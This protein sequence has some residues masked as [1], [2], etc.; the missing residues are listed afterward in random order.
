M[1]LIPLNGFTIF[2]IIVVIIAALIKSFSDH[3]EREHRKNNNRNRHPKYKYDSQ[4]RAFNEKRDIEKDIST[5]NKKA[6]GDAYEA[7]VGKL[8][9]EKGYLVKYQ[10]FEKG[11]KDG[12]IDLIAIKNDE[13]IFIQCKHWKKDGRKISLHMVKAFLTDVNDYI[14]QNPQCSEYHIQ[15]M[16]AISNPIFDIPALNYVKSKDDLFYK[17]IKMGYVDLDSQ[18]EDEIGT[19]E[20][21]TDT[22][23]KN[24]NEPINNIYDKDM[25]SEERADRAYKAFKD[26]KMIDQWK[27]KKYPEFF[28][29]QKDQWP[30]DI[31]KEKL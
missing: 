14:E 16:Y 28:K 3:N 4:K 1:D 25:S 26:V 17:I 18:S 30:T 31:F 10:G 5:D 8:F 21:P 7:H 15:K 22:N 19:E 2:I 23:D 27:Q 12:G 20:E 9:E 24:S 29:D 11:K 6:L 13:L